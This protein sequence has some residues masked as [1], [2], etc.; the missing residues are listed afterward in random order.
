MDFSSLLIEYKLKTQTKIK[1][2]F[3]WKDQKWNN[4]SKVMDPDLV[5]R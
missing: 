3:W 4:P 2:S 5:E 1:G